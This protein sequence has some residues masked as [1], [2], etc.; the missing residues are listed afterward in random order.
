MERAVALV[1]AQ[2]STG[3]VHEGCCAVGS[4]WQ[5]RAGGKLGSAARA[6]TPGP[7][8]VA[9][10]LPRRPE[11]VSTGKQPSMPEFPGARSIWRER[12]IKFGTRAQMAECHRGVKWRISFSTSLSSVA[13]SPVKRKSHY[14]AAELLCS[15]I[16]LLSE[17]SLSAIEK[18]RITL[19]RRV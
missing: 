18:A 17:R 16:G 12:K 5:P 1:G 8:P 2:K 19:S 15:E 14:S 13:R 10:L 3:R 11:S 7:A 9:K 6:R 4:P